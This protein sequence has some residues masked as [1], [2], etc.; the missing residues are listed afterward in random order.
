MQTE[1]LDLSDV[2]KNP[3]KL[4]APSLPRLSLNGACEE[5]TILVCLAKPQQEELAYLPE[6]DIVI[7]LSHQAKVKT[8]VQSVG[9]CIVLISHPLEYPC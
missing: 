2:K 4:G 9:W 6:E 3:E 5:E 8:V 1:R 7:R